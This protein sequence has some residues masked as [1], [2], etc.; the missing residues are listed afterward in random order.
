[1]PLHENPIHTPVSPQDG[2]IACI[3]VGGIVRSSRPANLHRER[4]A[5]NR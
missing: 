4:V 3:S 5:F 2:S 1:M